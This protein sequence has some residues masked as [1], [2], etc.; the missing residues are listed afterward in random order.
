MSDSFPPPAPP[1]ASQPVTAPSSTF[2]FSFAGLVWLVL[3]FGAVMVGFQ[4]SPS[5]FLFALAM[6]WYAYYLF[7]GGRWSF[8]IW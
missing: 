6:W 5:F 8:I 4:G 1:Q 7:R 2:R 3:G